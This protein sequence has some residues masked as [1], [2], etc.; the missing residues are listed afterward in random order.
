MLTEK[1]KKNLE[2]GNRVREIRMDMDYTQEN[3]AY[4]LGISLSAYK[5]I[6]SGTMTITIKSLKILKEKFGI[7]TDYILFGK[8][9]HIDDIEQI[10]E[11]MTHEEQEELYNEL[12]DYFVNQKKRVYMRK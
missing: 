6:E 4:E 3:M 1:R 9:N 12:V 2:I 8:F 10:I 5:K 7:S 11:G